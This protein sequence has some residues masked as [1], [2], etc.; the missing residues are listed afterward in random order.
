MNGLRDFGTSVYGMCK[1]A[2]SSGGGDYDDDSC[3]VQRDRELAF[4]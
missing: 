2:F 1:R 3:D 4:C